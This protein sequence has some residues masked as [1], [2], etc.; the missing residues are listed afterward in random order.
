MQEARIVTYPGVRPNYYTIDEYGNVY[1]KKTGK[2]IIPRIDGKGYIRI[3]LQSTKSNGNRIEVAVHRLVCWEFNGPYVDDEHSLVN[4]KD[5]IKN[6]N[7]PDNLEWC[8]NSENVKH[9]IETGLLVPKRM[10]NF[11]EDVIRIV[12]DLIIIGLSNIEIVDYVYNGIDIHSVEHA[13]LAHTIS[14]IR[15]GKSYNRLYEERKKNI[16]VSLYNNLDVSKIRES[17]K[18]TRNLKT[19]K[20]LNDLIIRYKNEGL[21]KV[22]ILEKITGYTSSCAT[23]YVRRV[24][25]HIDRIFK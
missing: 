5:G 14:E 20:E 16:D 22:E 17:V 9:A 19:D 11:D 13:N 7:N 12:C 24:Y 8:S 4:H 2:Q 10:F 21:S 3:Q 18:S 15:R 6:N 25:S 1:N 23:F